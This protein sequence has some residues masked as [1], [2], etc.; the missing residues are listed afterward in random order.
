MVHTTLLEYLMQPNPTLDCTKSSV[1]ANTYNVNWDPVTGLEEWRDFNYDMLMQ[2][3]I[4][5]QVSAALRVDWPLYYSNNNPNDIAEISKGAKA[6]RGTAEEDDRFYAD[7]AGIRQNQETVFGYK[8]LCPGDSKL[9]TKW[10]TSKEGQ[11]K[12]DF[13]TPLSQVQTYCG[14]QWGVRHGY[15]IT[16]EELVVVRVSR[17]L[18]G[19]GLAASRPV[20]TS[21]QRP[22]EQPTHA[23]T[24]SVETVSSGFQAM[25]LDTGSNFSDDANPNIEYGPLQ[26]KSIPWNAQGLD[27]MTVR[28]GLW[29]LLM[30]TKRDLS[31]QN[32]HS[33]NISSGY[34]IVERPSGEALMAGSAG[35]GPDNSKHKGKRPARK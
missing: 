32:Y 22:R 9:A 2:V 3:S 23:R 7:W 21:T 11:S 26:F 5:P 13:T 1:G 29:L 18:I 17:E 27:I 25:S 15:I 30:Q 16:P 8:N 12:S 20:R 14:R 34:D 33:P 28:L 4:M 31:V 35:S 6:R 19:P 10:S 24:F